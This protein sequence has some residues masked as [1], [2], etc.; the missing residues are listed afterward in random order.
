MH[1]YIH[2]H[3]YIHT[4]RCVGHLG[5]V[6]ACSFGGAGHAVFCSASE[7]SAVRVWETRTGVVISV[8]RGH[9]GHVHGCSMGVTGPQVCMYVC[10]ETCTGVVMSVFRGG[11]I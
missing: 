9:I 11:D 3:T 7:D 1:T 2:R 5:P 8:F 6:T 10:M 4:Y